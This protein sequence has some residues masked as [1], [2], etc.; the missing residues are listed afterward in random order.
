MRFFNRKQKREDRRQAAMLLRVA[1]GVI[2]DRGWTQKVLENG[3]G[4]VCP[5]GA[6]KKAMLPVSS[7]RYEQG[8]RA[9]DVA[10]RAMERRIEQMGFVGGIGDWNDML[11]TTEEAVTLLMTSVAD[12]LMEGIN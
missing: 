1:V 8:K 7:Y 10:Q 4:Q 5:I 12:S 6:M 9:F 3:K 11:Q 2:E